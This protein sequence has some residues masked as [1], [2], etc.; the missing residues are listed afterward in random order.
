MK[1]SWIAPCVGVGGADALMLGLCRHGLGDNIVVC[2]YSERRYIEWAKQMCP[3]VNLHAHDYG[4]ERQDGV[5]YYTTLADAAHAACYDA[6]IIITWC[7]RDIDPLVRTLNK[8]IVEL[9]QNG[10]GYAAEV[11]KGNAPFT[12][13]NVACSEWAGKIFDRCD[14]VIYNAIDPNRVTPRW[15]RDAIR[16]M[17]GLEDK[18]ILLFMGRLVD[19]KCPHS[20]IQALKDLPDE[21]V[22]LFVGDGYRRDD[23]IR[24]SQ[25]WLGGG[26]VFL[27]E[28]QFHVGDILAGADVFMLNSDFEGH[29]LAVCE[30]WLAGLPTVVSS[31]PPMLELREKFGDCAIYLENLDR[32]FAKA[33]IDA[34]NMFDEVNR[35]RAVAWEYFTLSRATVCWERFL[36][37]CLWQ[38]RNNKL[39]QNIYRINDRE[40]MTSAKVSVVEVQHHG[41]GR[42]TS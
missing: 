9:A 26:R 1:V 18:K 5:S 22:G 21:W 17:W 15:G 39:K 30:A 23:L 40:P 31:I 35:A 8:P 12:H 28:P 14:A 10:D 7:M 32:N 6:D 13:F 33:V 19:E 42:T 24:E 11:V 2:A 27:M 36:N 4:R 38:W 3:S 34:E 16:K 20:I 41:S 25:R 29:P 37:D